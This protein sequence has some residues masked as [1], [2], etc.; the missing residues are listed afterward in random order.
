LKIRPKE[1]YGDLL[2]N[3][4]QCVLEAFDNQEYPFDEMISAMDGDQS[5]GLQ[6]KM[7]VH[8]SLV[9]FFESEAEEEDPLF[10]PLDIEGFQ[11]TQYEFKLEVME[12]QGRF[13]IRFIYSRELYDDISIETMMGYYENLL[14]GVLEN[15]SARLEQLE[16]EPK[17]LPAALLR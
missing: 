13:Q 2:E 5:A 9:N 12:R 10:E 4:K 15:A 3:V 7:Q 11:T 17:V 16:M 8:F 14:T 6:P 1:M